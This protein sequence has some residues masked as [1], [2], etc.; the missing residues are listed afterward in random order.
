MA[1]LDRDEY[2][3]VWLPHWL[4]DEVLEE[5]YTGILAATER[6]SQSMAED[7][8]DGYIIRDW[9]GPFLLSPPTRFSR[10]RC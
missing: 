8:T 3:P 2:I 5:V 7:H 10:G 1:N 9:F 4:P 6:N